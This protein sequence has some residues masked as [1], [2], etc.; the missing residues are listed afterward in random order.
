MSVNIVLEVNDVR[1][2]CNFLEYVLEQQ[3]K[4]PNHE[5]WD[6]RKYN[7]MRINQILKKLNDN[8]GYIEYQR[9]IKIYRTNADAGIDID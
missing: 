3:K 9:R 7:E 6:D 1:D 8:E 5:G 2:I 4:E